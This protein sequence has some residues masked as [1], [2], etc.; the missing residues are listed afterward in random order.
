VSFIKKTNVKKNKN[1]K[2][3]L[4]FLSA[5]ALASCKQYL[6]V[7]TDPNNAT[8]TKSIYIFTNA[9]QQTA[10]QVTA[11]QGL[12]STW[13]G[14]WAHSTSFTGGSNEKT[15]V[16]T[17]NDFN[18]FDG[19]YDVLTDYEYVVNNAVKDGVGYLKGPAKILECLM[20]QKVVDLYG[21]VPY[22][23]ALKGTAFTYPVYDD[24][25]TIYED[26]ITKL[27]T[28]ISDINS[29]TWPLNEPQDIIF[30]GDK[31]QWIQFANSLKLRILIRQSN[32][33]GRDS[34]ITGAINAISGGFISDNVYAQPGYAKTAGKL[35]PF[36][37]TYGFDQNDLPTGTFAYRKMNK[38]IIDWLK[39]TN[40]TFRLQRLATPQEQIRVASG[41]TSNPADYQGVP[42]GSPVGYL[43]AVCSGIGSVQVNTNKS[44]NA[45]FDAGRPSILFTLAESEFL[46]AEAAT[47][48]GL[49]GSGATHYQAG[50]E[51]A[52]RLAAATQTGTSTATATTSNT[53]ADAYIL[54]AGTIGS[55][56]IYLNYTLAPTTADKL[57]TI[58]V[59]KWEA[60]CDIDGFE[61][62][63]EY[64][65][66]NTAPAGVVS[67]TGCIPYSPRSVTVTGAEPVRLFYPLREESVNSANVPQGIN[68]F[69]SK[70]FWDAN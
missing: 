22:S 51:A 60:L 7:N 44:L 11:N 1:M 23:Q 34:Y 52:F 64:R 65:R 58:Q 32:M 4:I 56:G 14:Y 20:W 24:A 25:K 9:E 42:M 38:V 39:N 37:Q 29:A 15:Y 59:Q 30:K 54:T 67:F 6:D 57:R 2:K 33:S 35:N 19:Y 48:Y 40:D 50:V 31:T 8:I 28:A 47:R 41:T 62:W 17:N 45:A 66:T 61:A 68:V 36:Y 18:F 3:Y 49:L 63:A 13:S 55:T 5:I 69:T 12:G 27:S 53:K 43:E 26:L 70:V 10:V 16:F 21:N 46:Q